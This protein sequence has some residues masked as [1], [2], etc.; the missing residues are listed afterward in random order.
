MMSLAV[1]FVMEAEAHADRGDFE[2]AIVCMK[3]MQCC[4]EST[5]Q[6]VVE[7]DVVIKELRRE[8][9]KRISSVRK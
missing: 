1:M 6:Q 4:I 2:M 3:N 7:A 5:V 8:Y 9:I